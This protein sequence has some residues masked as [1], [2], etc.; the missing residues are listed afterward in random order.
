M[1]ENNNTANEASENILSS[2]DIGF[3]K[4]ERQAIQTEINDLVRESRTAVTQDQL[5]PQ[6]ARSGL[7][8]PLIVNAILLGVVVAIVIVFTFLFSNREQQRIAEAQTFTSTESQL[9]RELVRQTERQLAEREAQI[10]SVQG[11]LTEVSQLLVELEE[12]IAT[13]IESKRSELQAEFEEALLAQRLQLESE[14]YTEEEVTRLLDELRVQAEQRIDSE[15]S[16]FEQQLETENSTRQAE[17]TTLRDSLQ[18]EIS[19]KQSEINQLRNSFQQSEQELLEAVESG[20]QTI[21][22]LEAQLA[23][24]LGLQGEFQTMSQQEATSGALATQVDAA[25][26]IFFDFLNQG[27]FD[28]SNQELNNIEALVRGLSINGYDRAELDLQTIQ[29]L[30]NYTTLAEA[31]GTQREQLLDLAG[32]DGTLNAILPFADLQTDYQ[33]KLTEVQDVANPS[34]AKQELLSVF[35]EYPSALPNFVATINQYDAEILDSLR[36]SNEEAVE[37]A[38]AQQ[39]TQIQQ[40]ADRARDQGVKDAYDTV[41]AALGSGQ[42]QQRARALRNQNATL[43]TMYDLIQDTVNEKVALESS[44]LAEEIVADNLITANSEEIGLPFIGYVTGTLGKKE[45]TFS[46]MAGIAVRLGAEVVIYRQTNDV[47]VRIGRAVVSRTDNSVI[48]A[49]IRES[50]VGEIKRQDSIYLSR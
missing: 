47:Y 25:F 31:G 15:V 4:E 5:R 11:E 24:A 48:Q 29:V 41:R 8:F 20:E 39:N 34:Q 32:D 40:T 46:N 36:E 22:D 38:R 12:G 21:A 45:F 33:A 43:A 6:A 28:Q 14:N 19:E 23:N 44:R 26:Q 35:D 9:I 50:D 17:L 49:V 1:E 37:A 16:L 27:D 18:Q 30:R 13:Q 42:F 10:Q 7:M 2:S 3:S